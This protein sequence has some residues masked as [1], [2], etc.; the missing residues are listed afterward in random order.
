[1]PYF[2]SL[3]KDENT[4]V[5][6]GK[7]E[8]G[9]LPIYITD[10]ATGETLKSYY[11][12]IPENAYGPGYLNVRGDKLVAIAGDQMVVLDLDLNEISPL[13]SLPETLLGSVRNDNPVSGFG[14]SATGI[15]FNDDLSLM[16]FT[17]SD[18][19]KLYDFDNGTV[20]FVPGTEPKIDP[21]HMIQKRGYKSAGIVDQGKKV[22]AWKVGWEWTVG[23]LLYDIES[24]EGTFYP[25]SGGYDMWRSIS[26]SGAPLAFHESTTG[27]TGPVYIDFATEDV[28]PLPEFKPSLSGGWIDTREPY[29]AWIDEISNDGG[30]VQSRIMI[31]DNKTGEITPTS[32]VITAP[33]GSIENKIFCTRDKKAFVSVSYFNERFSFLVS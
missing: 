24:G 29:S 28:S 16:V 11:L 8:N 18:G 19:V 1:M 12:P 30:L 13:S 17:D 25:Y 26:D 21:D 27:E 4:F 10:Y 7:L 32:C 20:T 3:G 9:K 23:Y 6:S 15:D 33:E 22:F 5:G 2:L 31:Q 14:M